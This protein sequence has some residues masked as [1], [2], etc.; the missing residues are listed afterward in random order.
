MYRSITIFNI[1]FGRA[2]SFIW[3]IRIVVINEPDETCQASSV[4]FRVLLLFSV[5]P[6]R[7]HVLSQGEGKARPCQG[8]RPGVGTGAMVSMHCLKLTARYH[9]G[10]C[11]ISAIIIGLWQSHVMAL[12]L[13]VG[14]TL[15]ALNLASMCWLLLRLVGDG[16]QAN[17]I[18]YAV[19]FALKFVAMLAV[20]AW[21]I[22]GLHLNALGL[23]LGLVFLFV[24][25]G[26][27]LLHQ[28]LWAEP[29]QLMQC[30]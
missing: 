13:V 26:L 9:M 29:K 16:T 11:A 12:A 15:M 18:L 8:R 7:L 6:R 27:A 22:L 25:L 30:E 1:C 19:A 21:L 17:K 3:V 28:L 5:K 4:D 20:L 23:M 14:G 10:V 24:G 2:S